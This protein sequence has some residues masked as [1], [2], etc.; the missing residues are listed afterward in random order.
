MPNPPLSSLPQIDAMTELVLAFGKLAAREPGLASAVLEDAI[1]LVPGK[2]AILAGRMGQTPAIFRFYLDRPEAHAGRDWKELTRT[3]GYMSG[4]DLT[5]NAPLF[6]HGPL[7]LVVVARADGTPLMDLIR[8]A[9]PEARAAA[10]APAAAWLRKYTAPT[11]EYAPVR[12]D[13][14]ESRAQKGMARQ[15]NARLRPLEAA[16][17]AEL[18]RIAAPHAGGDWRIAICHGDFHPNNLLAHGPRLTGID[19]GG[20]ARLP[21]YKDMARFLG[22][23]G[24]RGLIPSGKMRFAVDAAGLDAFARAFALDETERR[25]WL[26]YMIGIETLLRI[27]ARPLPRKRLRRAARFY[28]ALLADLREIGA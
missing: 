18:Q 12:L 7:G 28:E 4:G 27:D 14:W 10:L 1:R 16:L 24:R 22:H 5:V 9:E 20:S 6:H 11:E 26:P 21:V 17:Y 2:R 25:I 3:E 23:M 8:R 13:G 15:P 19:T